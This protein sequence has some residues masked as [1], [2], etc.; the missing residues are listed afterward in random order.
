MTRRCSAILLLLVL[1]GSAVAN[2]PQPPFPA[3]PT[4]PRPVRSGYIVA[5]GVKLWYAEFGEGTPVILIEGGLD[6]TD[7]WAYLA[8]ELAAHGYRAIVFDSRCQGKST[9][10]PTALGYRLM[11]RDTV[12][13]MN[14]LHV[15]RRWST[16]PM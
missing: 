6:T 16:A 4:L 8:P 3:T 11:A 5:D 10:N 12:G 1:A 9:C 2:Q 13:L 15:E 14:A 7:D